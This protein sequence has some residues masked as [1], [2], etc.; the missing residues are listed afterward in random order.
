MKSHIIAPYLATLSVKAQ[1]VHR[2]AKAMPLSPLLL[3]LF[4]LFLLVPL[5]TSV[6]IHMRGHAASGGGRGGGGGR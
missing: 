6:I 4:P 3:H 5:L 2:P 1:S